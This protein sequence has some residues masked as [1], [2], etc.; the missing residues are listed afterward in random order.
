MKTLQPDVPL[1]LTYGKW[2]HVFDK[3]DTVVEK[4]SRVGGKILASSEREVTW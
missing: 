1:H 4:V 2:E 3:N